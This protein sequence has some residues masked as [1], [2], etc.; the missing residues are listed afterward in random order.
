MIT[1]YCMPRWET[2]FAALKKQATNSHKYNRLTPRHFQSSRFA[3]AAIVRMTT[4]IRIAYGIKIPEPYLSK[5][6][7]V[8]IMEI[9]IKS[10]C[11]PALIFKRV[12]TTFKNRNGAVSREKYFGFII[13]P[14][15]YNIFSKIA[16][17]LLE[18]KYYT[19]NMNRT[20]VRT[21]GARN[22]DDAAIERLVTLW[23]HLPPEEQLT[24]LNQLE[25][26]AAALT[27]PDRQV[28]APKVQEEALQQQI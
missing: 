2:W 9:T 1:L 15:L 12:F 16:V 17:A 6:P 26:A 5:R 28:P 27:V 21:K 25:R 20:N 24:Y 3:D 22:M 7:K 23:K 8:G 18:Q 11:N 14:S 19:Q 13:Q 4:P 10:I